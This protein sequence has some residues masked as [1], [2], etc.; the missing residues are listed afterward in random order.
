MFKPDELTLSLNS[1]ISDEQWDRLT[2]VELDHTDKIVFTTKAGKKVEFV[3]VVRC[4]D[5][6]NRVVNEHRGEKGYMPLKAM[7]RLD[8][9]DIFELG[10]CADNDKWFC[11]DGDRREDSDAFD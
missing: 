7:C 11:A 2:D 6:V 4:E 10:R 5:C 3:K 9:G 1:P 8:T